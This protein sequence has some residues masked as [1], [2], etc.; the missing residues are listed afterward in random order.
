MRFLLALILLVPAFAQQPAI[1]GQVVTDLPSQAAQTPAKP[2]DPAAQAPAKADEKA[3]QAPAKPDEKSAQAPAKTEAKAESPTPSTEQWLSG[4]IDFGYRWLTNVRGNFAEYR[5]VV[6]LGEGPKLFGL[7]LTFQDPKKRLFDRVDLRAY[8]FGGDPYST[9]HL[10]ARKMG[11]YDLTFDYRNIAYFNAVPSF[12]NPLSPAGFNEQSFDIHRRNM[13]FG[14]DLRPGKHIIPYLAFERNSGYG[15]GIDTWVQ[16]AND[17][18]AVPTLLRDSTN[19]FRGGVRFEYNRFHVTVEQGG[20]TFKDDDQSYWNGV[21]FGDRTTLVLGQTEV[22]YGLAQ[23]YGIRGTSVYTKV[24]A[25]ANLNDSVNFYGQFLFSEPKTDV[26]YTDLAVGNFA[27]LSSL[28]LYSGQ[29]NLGTGAANQPHTSFTFG[30]QGRFRQRL[31]FIYSQMSDRYH[32]AASPLLTQQLLLNATTAAPKT[33]DALAYTQSVNYNQSQ[34]D[35]MFDLTS[36]I[37][38]RGGYRLVFG[39]ATVLAGRLSQTGPLV[40]GELHRHVGLGGL[41]FRPSE[42]LSVNLDYEGA[43]SD[44]IYFRTSLNDY[45]KARARA[46]YQLNP[47][48]SFQANFQVLNNQN[49]AADIRYDF[50]SRDNSL[51]VYWTPASA[52]RITVMGEYD[53]STLSSNIA[54]LGLFLSPITSIYHDRAHTATSAI[55]LALPGLAGAKLTAGGSLFIASGT[56]PS[57]YYQPL[58]R[59][60]LPLHK[61]VNW[62][63]E[64]QYYGFGEQFFLFEGFRTHVFMTGLRVT[65]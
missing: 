9:A 7:D 12:A 51:A 31:R 3:A 20:T 41:T 4:N 43:S 61:H 2:D 53:R 40:S 14:L 45:H 15:H 48:L 55:D 8:G 35:V 39:D 28:L 19:N 57:R 60:S 10:D 13:S 34:V 63:T 49:P 65:R 17:E 27:A 25:T 33:F 30:W 6:N 37:T 5:S 16:D 62:N 21:N 42:K 64:W 58:A 46:K 54:Y 47:S 36:K 29:Q 1:V 26:H 32:D 23:A 52:K 38:L 22:L 50:Q 59:L 24:L 56:R 44:R 18:F 11:S